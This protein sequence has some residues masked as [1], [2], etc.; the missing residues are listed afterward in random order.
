MV[1]KE[2]RVAMTLACRM[3][4]R[5]IKISRRSLAVKSS[6]LEYTILICSVV[7]ILIFRQGKKISQAIY[8]NFGQT[9]S[10]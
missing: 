7:E 8:V 2:V 3:M 10:T 4:V 5:K 9:T 1:T 6:L